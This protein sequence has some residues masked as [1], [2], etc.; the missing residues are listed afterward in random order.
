M[1]DLNTQYGEIRWLSL[2]HELKKTQPLT[3]WN[4]YSDKTVLEW[5]DDL[6]KGKA[7]N[8]S[9]EAME[10]YYLWHLDGGFLELKI[11]EEETKIRV[12]D[13]PIEERSQEAFDLWKLL[14]TF[15]HR[16]DVPICDAFSSWAG[17][18]GVGYIYACGVCQP[19]KIDI[20][21]D[22]NKTIA[23]KLCN[24]GGSYVVSK[25]LYKHMENHVK[26][27]GQ[28]GRNGIWEFRARWRGWY[29][30]IYE[31]ALLRVLYIV[32][33][34]KV[35]A[36]YDEGFGELI[37]Y[38]IPHDTPDGYANEHYDTMRN[39]LRFCHL[40]ETVLDPILF[41]ESEESWKQEVW[42]DCDRDTAIEVIQR[43]CKQEYP[44]LF[45][46]AWDDGNEE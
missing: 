6:H 14:H 37:C 40:V 15:T 28:Y 20:A 18:D 22:G 35:G 1:A 21:K 43:F 9:S 13:K 12:M 38:P 29:R 45:E 5:A 10:I 24:S 26:Q 30:S 19:Q 8:I 16:Y 4:Q 7:V 41:G 33:S 25:E 36:Y 44:C 32:T 11:P 34:G 42:A 23:L 46:K 27:Y 2:D 31:G 39:L 17:D 3:E